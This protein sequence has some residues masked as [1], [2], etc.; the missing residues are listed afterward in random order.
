M[1]AE[2]HIPG[3][4]VSALVALK[5]S[6]HILDGNEKRI[7]ARHA[8]WRDT[9]LFGLVSACLRISILLLESESVDTA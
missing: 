1:K 8:W 2:V 4:F 6:K 3:V 5:R 9:D 7:R